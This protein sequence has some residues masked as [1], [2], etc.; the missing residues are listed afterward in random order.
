MKKV[1]GQENAK[2]THY[3]QTGFTINVKGTTL[4]KKH[5]GRKRPT[6]TNPK[7]LENSNRNTHIYTYLKCNALIASTKRHKLAEWIQK[8]DLICMLSTRDPLQT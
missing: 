1:Y 5:K 6:E 2:R 3:H 8:Q 4:R 7:H